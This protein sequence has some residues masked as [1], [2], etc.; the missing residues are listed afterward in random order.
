MEV[1][2]RDGQIES[3]DVLKIAKAIYKARLDAGQNK[4]LEFC[5]NEAKTITE[6][7]PNG[8]KV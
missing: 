7:L 6:S 3:F 4:D 8:G 2:K 1:K 5:V